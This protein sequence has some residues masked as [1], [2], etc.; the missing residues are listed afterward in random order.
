MGWARE[1]RAIDM[2]VS[3]EATLVEYHYFRCKQ[4]LQKPKRLEN[5]RGENFMPAPAVASR[6]LGNSKQRFPFL[7]IIDRV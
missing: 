6:S 7:G 2:A 5:E 1:S 3:L 4:D